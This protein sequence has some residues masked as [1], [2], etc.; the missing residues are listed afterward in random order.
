MFETY[1]F[2]PSAVRKC[3]PYTTRFK[4]NA[5][6]PYS[7]YLSKNNFAYIKRVRKDQVLGKKNRGNIEGSVPVDLEVTRTLSMLKI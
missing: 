5:T 6:R 4:T 2:D 7:Y 1:Y 3:I